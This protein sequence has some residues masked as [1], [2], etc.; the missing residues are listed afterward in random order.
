MANLK[1]VRNRI[2]SVIST[3]QITNNNFSGTF[4]QTRF[5]MVAVQGQIP[6]VP[7]QPD[8]AQVPTIDGNTP[9]PRGSST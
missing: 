6:G 2:A 4:A 3:Q 8:A 1:E 7:W 5:D 9:W